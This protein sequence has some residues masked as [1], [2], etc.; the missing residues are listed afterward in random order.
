MKLPVILSYNADVC[1][2]KNSVKILVWGFSV[3]GLYSMYFLQITFMPH[4][5]RT[6]C[7]IVHMQYM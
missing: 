2:K 4:I 1:K 3:L 5:F 7:F 6:C